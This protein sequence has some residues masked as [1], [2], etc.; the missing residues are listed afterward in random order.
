MITVHEDLLPYP[1]SGVVVDFQID[2]DRQSM[3]DGDNWAITWGDDDEQYSF[4]TDGTGFGAPDR[5]SAAPV[6]ISGTPPAIS[7]VNIPTQ[8]GVIP[9]PSGRNTRKVCGIAMI[10][11]VLYA[12]VRNINL[13][14]TPNGTGSTLMFSDDYGRDWRWVDWNFPDIGYPTWV[15]MGKNYGEARDRY[16]YFISP[17]GPSAYADYANMI[18]ARV[19]VDSILSR[20]RYR[21]VTGMEVDGPTW[22]AYEDRV[23]VFSDEAG[24]FRPD[25]VYNPG[26]GRFLLTTGSPYG[27]W[28]W[29]DNENPHRG[30]H[31]GVFDAPNPW[32]PWT[33]VAYVEDWGKPENRFAPHI[34]SKWISNDGTSFY[35]LY[36]CIPNGPYRFNIQRCSVRAK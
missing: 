1:P 6:V 14:G 28:E 25:M 13:P 15:N 2:P 16:A 3:G 21:F 8:T 26:L 29:W 17:D 35:L 19:S 27:D 33:T 36:S 30:P 32:G 31:L 5:V 4:F 7:G 23:P 24:C 18:L 10:D 20:N 22:G 9:E 34:P 11:G 12:W